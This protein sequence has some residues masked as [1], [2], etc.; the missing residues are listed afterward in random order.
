[1]RTV[2]IDCDPGTDDAIALFLALGSPEL[3]VVLVTAVGGNVGLDHTVRNAR[4]LVGLSG[5][6][7]P[8]VAGADRPMLGS[9]VAEPRVHGRNG[10]PGTTCTSCDRPY[11]S[12]NDSS[13]FSR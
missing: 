12:S 7:V 10:V 4:A 1:M 9:F 5:K 13:L 8:V 2:I 11:C 3:D 6:D